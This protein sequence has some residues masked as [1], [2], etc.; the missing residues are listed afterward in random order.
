[1]SYKLGLILFVLLITGCKATDELEPISK[2]KPS[3]ASEGTLA[4]QTLIAD[5]TSALE[6]KLGSNI[7]DGD[8]LKFVIQQPVGQVGSRAWREM[9]IVKSS[10]GGKQFIMTFRESGLGAADF[11]IKEM[12]K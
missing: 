12:G 6:I 8:I 3:V 1:M 10:E 4:N 9:W 5:V 11:E 7:E 2:I